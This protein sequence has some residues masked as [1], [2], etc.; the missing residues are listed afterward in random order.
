MRGDLAGA[1]EKT[2]TSTGYPTATSTLRVYQFRHDRSPRGAGVSRGARLC[3]ARGMSASGRPGA[4]G[5]SDARRPIAVLVDREGLGDVLLKRPFLMALRAAFPGHDVWWIATHQSSMADELAPLLGRHVAKV[6]TGAALDG[7]IGPLRQRL[8]ALPPFERVFDSRTKLTT[9][10][11]ARLTLQH[12]G[13]YCCLPGYL[14]CDGRPPSRRRPRHIAERM[15]SLIV[16]ATGRPAE[17]PPALAAS[18]EAAAAARHVLPDGPTYVG[19]A[20]GS[21]QASKNWPLAR[22]CE[23]ARALVAEGLTPVFFLGPQ[24]GDVE[25]SIAAAAP[26]ALV[27]HAEPDVA[28]GA[29]LDRLIAQGQRL[30]A[31]LANDN[32]VGH[33]MGAA[34]VPVVSLFGPTDPARW[35][36]V[37]PA[38]RIVRAQD[39]GGGEMTAI[40]VSAA[41]QAVMAML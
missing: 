30:A 40:P 33:L 27:V 8:A 13:F 38:G 16:C 28:P 15:T 19:I 4:R 23:T 6:I 41:V 11:A 34:G 9:V 39:F 1:V 32:G 36:P 3:E 7:P 5:L 18:P 12:R 24:E 29:G 22:F 20:P 31:L 10:A 25:A 17:P 14:L 37:A 2:R 26:G 35:A 21:R